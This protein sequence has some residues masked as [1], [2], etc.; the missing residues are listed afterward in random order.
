MFPDIFSQLAFVVVLAAVLGIIARTIHQPPIL[1]YLFAGIFI[2]L[3]GFFDF[4]HN[5]EVFHVFSDLGITLLLFLVGLEVNYRILQKIGKDALLIGLG[6]VLGTFVVSFLIAYTFDFGLL[7]SV[8]IGLALTFSST[9][10]VISL[11]SDKKD[12]N[13]VYGKLAVGILLIQ[14][15]VV[16]LA[17]VLLAG[18]GAADVDGFSSIVTETIVLESSL[19]QSVLSGTLTVLFGVILFVIAFLLSRNVVPALFARIA[20]SNELVFLTSLAWFFAITFLV[21]LLG[22]SKEIGGFVAGLTLAN[23]VESLHIAQ[24]MKTLKDFFI[25]IFFV[26]LGTSIVVAAD[27]ASLVVPIILLSLFVIIGNGLIVFFIATIFLRYPVR[28][29]FLAGVTIAQVSE[30]SII[31]VALGNNLGHVNEEVVAIVTSVAVVTITLSTYFIMHAEKAFKVMRP[32]L[33]RFERRHKKE[34]SSLEEQFTKPVV[35]IGF[36]RTGQNIV[37]HL[38]KEDI[39][40][41]EYDPETREAIENKKLPYVFGDV[42]DSS[43]WDLIDLSSVKVIVS[44]S[45]DIESNL[46]LLRFLVNERVKKEY[47]Y[48]VVI[49][50]R[51]DSE[52]KDL[53]KKGADYVLLPHFSLGRYF[54]RV[55]SSDPEL[56]TLSEMKKDDLDHMK[57]HL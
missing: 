52:A 36:H 21:D 32:L 8:Y 17:L 10:V 5:E 40:V 11:L 4:S 9:I 15:F 18:I 46:L 25:M 43:L 44:T 22:F 54:S 29:A 35:V 33:S 41:I 49:R 19:A 12:L 55:L 3:S 34:G 23:S 26:I 39:L 6:Q 14:D 50:A 38:P 48:K 28:V 24:R 7:A 30:F 2:G 37:S 1:A 45:P 42:S 56:T 57:K 51:T 20:K 16:V 53:Y 13:N 31:L 47:I 27:I